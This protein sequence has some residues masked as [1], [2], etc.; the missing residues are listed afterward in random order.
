MHI[1]KNITEALIFTVLDTE[2]TKDNVKARIDQ[3]QLC[4]REKLKLVARASGKSWSKPPASFSPTKP[5]RKEILMW[6]VN[7]LFF[8]DEYAANIMRGVNMRTQRIGGLK[9]HDYHVW[10]ERIMPVMIRGYV[11][12]DTWW[13]LV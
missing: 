11:K 13:V 2:K 12:E 6:I 8:P 4:D 9:S 5:Q 1:E 7:R 3:A 10:L